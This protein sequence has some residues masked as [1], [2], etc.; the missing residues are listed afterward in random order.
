MDVLK[1]AIAYSLGSDPLSLD[2]LRGKFAAK[3][4]NSP[5]GERL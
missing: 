2:R 5:E 1:A 3:M 4:A